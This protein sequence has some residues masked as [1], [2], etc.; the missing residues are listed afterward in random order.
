[1]AQS[2]KLGLVH[3]REYR[4]KSPHH[5]TLPARKDQK[6]T[7]DIGAKP[8]LLARAREIKA[9]DLR[10]RGKSH[11]ESGTDLGVT[12]AAAYQIVMRVFEPYDCGH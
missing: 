1:M 4:H 11:S 2:D 7:L 12:P 3:K 6:S 8:H 10:Q 5:D 9:L